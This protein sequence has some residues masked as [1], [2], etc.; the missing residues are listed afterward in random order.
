M[1][2]WL[3]LYLIVPDGASR[4]W[5]LFHVFQIKSTWPA[6]CWEV[7]SY[8]VRQCEWVNALLGFIRASSWTYCPGCNELHQW[9][10]PALHW[11][12]LACIL[13]CACTQRMSSPLF[14]LSYYIR[15]LLSLFWPTTPILAHSFLPIPH[16]ASFSFIFNFFASA[17]H[18]ML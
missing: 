12:V 14:S 13:L 4:V 2:A 11:H 3:G 16:F 7:C 17:F 8:T 10:P 9:R 6:L 18:G 15:Q 5:C 1:A